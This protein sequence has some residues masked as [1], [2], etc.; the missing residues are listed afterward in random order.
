MM[1]I[2]CLTVI[3]PFPDIHFLMNLPCNVLFSES[4]GCH[5][6][7]MSCVHFRECVKIRPMD[8]GHSLLKGGAED[9][10]TIGPSVED[11]PT[12][13]SCLCTTLS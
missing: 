1:P 5:F 11:P 4:K 13:F 10:R 12:P 6:C 7:E 9:G 2:D 3:V 8:C